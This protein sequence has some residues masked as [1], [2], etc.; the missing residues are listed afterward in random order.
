MK[1]SV[2]AIK[3]RPAGTCG[4]LTGCQN[5]SP[6]ARCPGPAGSVVTT[7]CQVGSPARR[8]GCLPAQATI[9][10]T[11][12]TC[13]SPGRSLGVHSAH[14]ALSK[15]DTPSHPP[16]NVLFGLTICPVINDC[17]STTGTEDS[18]HPARRVLAGLPS[19]YRTCVCISWW[20]WQ[21]MR[22]GCHRAISGV[23]LGSQDP[24]LRTSGLSGV[25][26]SPFA[27]PGFG[28]QDVLF[29]IDLP[30]IF[31]TAFPPHTWPCSLGSS[32]PCTALLRRNHRW[33]PR[34][35]QLRPR[36]AGR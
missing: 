14:T 24:S 26:L 16:E 3:R 2:G 7:L 19:S 29:C 34:C 10:C 1:I 27:R 20:A 9:L 15:S 30:L 23:E 21:I 35:A 11:E 8:I 33:P 31:K 22:F 5:T 13:P 18:C 28:G 36:P 4:K 12:I 6:L 17:P 25:A 32:A